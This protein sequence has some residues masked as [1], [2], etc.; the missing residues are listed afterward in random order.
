MTFCRLPNSFE[1]NPRLASRLPRTKHHGE[2]ACISSRLEV[3]VSPLRQ[4]V[5]DLVAPER[6]HN[7][8]LGYDL[9]TS[10]CAVGAL[11]SR[12]CSSEG[13]LKCTHSVVGATPPPSPLHTQ[14]PPLNV[15]PSSTPAS[16]VNPRRSNDRNQFIC[17]R[18]KM[19]AKLPHLRI[20][21]AFSSTPARRGHVT[22]KTAALHNSHL[23]IV[24]LNISMK[25][26]RGMNCPNCVSWLRR[27]TG[28]KTRDF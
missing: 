1:Y 19:R 8:R 18:G 15:I 6:C 13:A 26:Q 23:L 3:C 9:F 5:K 11:E 28:A 22:V 12:A 10:R 27:Q 25:F 24:L 16:K 4:S 7:P 14:S 21:P 20:P 2:F 17:C